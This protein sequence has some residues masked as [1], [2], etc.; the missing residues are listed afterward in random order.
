M[1]HLCVKSCLKVIS[2]W[3]MQPTSKRVHWGYCNYLGIV[4]RF[5]ISYA[6]CSVCIPSDPMYGCKT[7][8]HHGCLNVLQFTHTADDWATQHMHRGF[9]DLASLVV[10]ILLRNCSERVRAHRFG[11]EPPRPTGRNFEI[12]FLLCIII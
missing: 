10:H 5:R 8:T 2:Y 1:F 9:Y 12:L 3:D 11:K 4:V 7:L 6:C